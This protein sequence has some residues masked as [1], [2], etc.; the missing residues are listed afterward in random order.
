MCLS[1]ILNF[2]SPV[3]VRVFVGTDGTSEKISQRLSFCFRCVHVSKWSILRI[4]SLA[5]Q[6]NPDIRRLKTA[7]VPDCNF[8]CLEGLKNS[9]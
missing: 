2:D 7:L 6:R 3:R 1:S 9:S 4:E 8:D 5:H